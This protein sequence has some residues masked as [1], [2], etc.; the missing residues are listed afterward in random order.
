MEEREGICI[1]YW[2]AKPG[3]NHWVALSKRQV[4]ALHS[5]W[6]DIAKMGWPGEAFLPSSWVHSLDVRSCDTSRLVFS[7]VRCSVIR[8][9]ARRQPGDCSVLLLV[10]QAVFTALSLLCITSEISKRI[11]KSLV[12]T[13][14]KFWEVWATELVTCG[15]LNMSLEVDFYL[16]FLC[17]H[18]EANC[19]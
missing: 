5:K 13:R 9:P 14:T 16:E 19:T 7:P 11:T 17:L 3:H 6:R 15:I 1:L 10:Y 12:I 2:D 8:M 18:S 4:P